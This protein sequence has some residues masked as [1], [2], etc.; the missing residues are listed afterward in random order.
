MTQVLLKRLMLEGFGRFRRPVEVC[1]SPGINYM[2]ADNESGKSS[3]VSGLLA[4]IFGMPQLSNPADFGQGRFRNWEGARSFRGE[5]EFE[6]DR[7]IYRI[8]R[9]FETNRISFSCEEGGRTVPLATGVH[10]PRAMRRNEAYEDQL[11]EIL[12][13]GHRE[14]FEAIFCVT[15]P[16]PE[17]QR[18]GQSVQEVLSGGGTGFAPVLEGLA[19]RLQELTRFTGDLGVTGQNMRKD[20]Q[21]QVLDAKISSLE[22]E[23][24]GSRTA[25]DALEDLKRQAVEVAEDQARDRARLREKER[26]RSNW[27]EWRRM[28]SEYRSRKDEQRRVNRVLEDALG[29]EQEVA[30]LLACTSRVY[31]EFSGAPEDVEE[32]LDELVDLRS[33]IK[34][35]TGDIEESTDALNSLR[36]R[37]AELDLHIS[38]HRAW[39]EI[40]AQPEE[41][42]RNVRRMVGELLGDWETFVGLTC[43]IDEAEE[44]LS[45]RYGILRR[46][47]EA[48]LEAVASYVQTRRELEAERE[49]ANEQLQAAQRQIQDHERETRAFEQRY[50]DIAEMDEG[51]AAAARQRLA[52]LEEREQV[53]DRLQ[54]CE[55]QL[56]VPTGW[57]LF[58]A[59][60]SGSLGGGAAYL[61][62]GGGTGTALVAAV[63]AIALGYL[64]F[65]HLCALRRGSLRRTGGELRSRLQTIEDRLAVPVD[66]LGSFS[67]AGLAELARLEERL[68]IR[69]GEGEGLGVRARELPSADERASLQETASRA[70]AKMRR[71]LQVTRPFV[72]AFTDPGEAHSQWQDLEQEAGRLRTQRERY[73]DQA[74]GCSEE[75][76]EEQL[77][78]E[79]R[80]ARW[81]E[82]AA[83]FAF[84]GLVQGH[85]TIA[86]LVEVL[87]GC[88]DR[89]WSELEED[90][91]DYAAASSEREG[92]KKEIAA[93]RR[94][95][96]RQRH[97]MKELQDL[98]TARAAKLDSI[99]A[100]SNGDAE[101]ARKRYNRWVAKI[102][103]I[104]GARARLKENLRQFEVSSTEELREIKLDADNRALDCLRRWH[105]L[106]D[107]NPG[108]PEVDE[109]G[110]A[111]QIDRHLRELDAEI[112]SLAEAVEEHEERRTTL[113]GQQ[114]RIEGMDPMNIAQAEI[115]L[116]VL[117]AEREETRLL[118]EALALAHH[119]VRGAI[120][121]VQSSSREYLQELA[122][123]QL[124]ALTGVE[125]RTV[126]IGEGFEVG[127]QQQGRSCALEQLSKGA[128][129]QLYLALRFAVADLVAAEVRLPFIFDDPFVTWDA[130]RRENLRGI[131]GREAD[132]R[133]II[134]LSHSDN[135]AG[136]GTEIAIDAAQNGS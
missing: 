95:I 44:I 8:D 43:E 34:D 90:A 17:V 18:L 131:L 22:A 87:R 80:D 102:R 117:R 53:R 100:G 119:G 86:Q 65:P 35:A 122:T 24:D 72:E 51:A 6:I 10:N 133:Q 52:L 70:E 21:L 23:I 27:A 89:W 45:C 79:V 96:D 83:F 105:E 4:V 134:V 68:R 64:I 12:R 36:D 33:R 2:V 7:A 37:R 15:Q 104:D 60:L 132:R 40:S 67:G 59:A 42:I 38:G 5:L 97:R 48:S 16:T 25:V 41:R 20:R 58:A 108:L 62:S 82:V 57:R 26:T 1:F 116:G 88:T 39:G 106:V 55:E 118:A 30:D 71:F 112:A 109:A 56:V 91:R 78:C 101:G 99:L 11:D 123:E 66:A 81:G 75:E 136:W 98:E 14:A 107:A 92:L 120:V 46:A 94:M 29:V 47:P 125:G 19:N 103:S 73:L 3:L 113:L 69:A 121:T 126:T 84:I 127:L 85:S 76:V 63:F 115:T 50:R 28:R 31:P 49:R 54:S 130:R 13:V 9:D 124:C 77:P 110:D 111:Q 128:R 93:L 32:S 129:D 61:L 114:S 74:F 135:Y